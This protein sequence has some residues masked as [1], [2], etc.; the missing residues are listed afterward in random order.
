MNNNKSNTN[1]FY[2]NAIE[3]FGNQALQFII[4]IVLARILSPND[5]GLVGILLVFIAVSQIF[6]DSGFT[7]ALIQRNDKSK[8]DLSTAFTFNLGIAL[9]IY[10]I[11]WFSAPLIAHFY[12]EILLINLLRTLSIIL[13]IN[14]L[15]TIPNTILTI[16][17]EFRSIAI[18]NSISVFIS[19]AV[20][21]YLAFMGYGVWSL[22][23]QYLLR[24]LINLIFYSIK[25]KWDYQLHFSI[26]SFK[27]LFSFGSNLLIS[28]LLNV[29]VDK[30]S[31]LF[32]AKAISTRE[33]GFYTR[34]IQFPDIAIGTL[35]SVLDT[36][37][38]PTLAKTKDQ[39][40][41][42][43]QLERI[44]NLLTLL[45]LPITIVL[46]VLSKSI[47]VFLLTE[48]WLPVVPIMQLFCISRFFTNLIS[49]N[50]NI[51]YVLNKTHLALKQN[52]IKIV[53]RVG[54]ILV[55]LPYGIIY[56][57]AA[58]AVSGFIHFL[59][60]TYY[61]GKII[62]FGLK[63]QLRILLPYLLI[64]IVLFILLTALNNII[65]YDFLNILLVSISGFFI[66][67]ILLYVF[68][69]KDLLLIKDLII[70]LTK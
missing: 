56:I 10:L 36:V 47:I 69:K 39:K 44:I 21:I 51:L 67:T 66:Y 17:L 23:I 62:N 46:V 1:S 45:T 64:G 31:S 13:I 33:L 29:V 35:G 19:G 9:F 41:F 4:G 48:K 22:V 37:L 53:I 65:T 52:Y 25:S 30:F 61:P 28:S 26:T 57:A 5:Y 32:I 24:A 27:R 38:L 2:W 42:K 60:N 59:I 54:L 3:K 68:K 16:D 15:F 14:A 50:V 49:V 12:N 11:L 7:K 34:G 40:I 63:S 18:I 43:L 70:N 55:A 20:S 6:V 8:N 58:E